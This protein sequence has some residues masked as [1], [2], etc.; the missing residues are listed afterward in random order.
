MRVTFAFLAAIALSTNWVATNAEQTSISA[1][2]STLAVQSIRAVH[3]GPNEQR[4]LRNHRV[5]DEDDE[6]DSDDGE[7]RFK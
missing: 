4:F 6:E 3:G 5:S 7:E 2:T 1:T